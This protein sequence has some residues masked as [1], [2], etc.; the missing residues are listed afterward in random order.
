[1]DP[2]ER[3]QAESESAG[4]WDIE[5]YLN[6]Q[7]EILRSRVLAE[8]VAQRLRQ[9]GLIRTRDPSDEESSAAG[10]MTAASL[11]Q[12]N[13]AANQAQAQRIAAEARWNAE[14]AQPLFSSQNV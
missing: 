6:T 1:M 3:L 5:L 9:A 11:M 14:Q 12:L 8:R 7:S 2:H 13:E 4:N 10:S